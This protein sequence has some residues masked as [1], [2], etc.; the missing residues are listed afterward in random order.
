MVER[1]RG[2]VPESQE[3]LRTLPGVG[4][5]TAAA[6]ASFAFGLRA[7]VVD[8]NVRRVLARVASGSAQA[9]PSLTRAETAL[10][11]RVLPSDDPTTRSWNVAVMELGAL[12]CTARSPQCESCPVA[13]LC[14]WQIA[15]GPAYEGPVRRAQP[16]HG[17]DRQCRGAILAVLRAT[18]EPV[19]ATKLGAAWSGDDAQR[20]R[21]LD[22][23]V[24]DA[25]VEPLPHNR[26]RLP[27]R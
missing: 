9:A 2:R 21:C 10:A 5:Y 20:D 25:L 26:F 18:M 27:V 1:H 22:S 8:T 6:V 24:A 23:L 16:W 11:L 4:S 12:I 14:A 17:T 7:A 15:G 3:A 13:D 19:T